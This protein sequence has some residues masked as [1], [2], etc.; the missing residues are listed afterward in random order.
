MGRPAEHQFLGSTPSP[1]HPF[2]N[3]KTC[4][5][6]VFSV[7][8]PLRKCKDCGVEA[9]TEDELNSFRKVKKT[10]YGRG[11]WCKKCYAIYVI[12]KIRKTFE[13]LIKCEICGTKLHRITAWHLGGFCCNLAQNEKNIVV[14]NSEHYKKLFPYAPLMS[15][16]QL[17]ILSN[18][19][20]IGGKVT[21]SQFSA[22]EKKAMGKRLGKWYLENIPREK[23]VAWGRKYAK[24]GG[25]LGG[26]AYWNN[27]SDEEKEEKTKE[28]NKRFRKYWDGL[29]PEQKSAHGRRGGLAALKKLQTP[30]KQEVWLS[31]V[32]SLH[33]FSFNNVFRVVS[34]SKI[35]NRER[36]MVPDFIHSKLPILI[37]F[38]GR[39]GHDVSIPWV[40]ENQPLLDDERD[41][42]YK[43]SGYEIIRFKSE[44]L[45]LGEVHIIEQ[46]ERVLGIF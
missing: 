41:I 4:Y 42:L 40:P 30:N 32:L 18:A 44:D 9:W 29:T 21:M 14:P 6:L 35:L 10:P 12:N 17:N 19:G 13:G 46:V 11:N 31:K 45:E 43:E 2:I 23:I 33:G 20:K 8:I 37:E 22:E 28:W 26:K 15:K 3:Q 16:H 36:A 27:L 7:D 24:K 34:Y 1:P 39:G 38:D 5:L 25:T